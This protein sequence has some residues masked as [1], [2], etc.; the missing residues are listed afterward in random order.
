MTLEFEMAKK[1]YDCLMEEK[2]KVQDDLQK[3][4]FLLQDV[5]GVFCIFFKML[6]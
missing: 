3:E 5:E 4:R 6:F 2:L 1:N